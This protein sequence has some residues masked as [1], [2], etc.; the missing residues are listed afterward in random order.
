VRALNQLEVM[1]IAG[2]EGAS[3]PFLS[4]DGQW[5]GFATER[6]LRKVA[7]SGGPPTTIGELADTIYGA[8]WGDDGSIVD[9]LDRL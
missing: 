1:P 9:S 8:S 7:V 4:P 6:A 5:I 2:T 3:N